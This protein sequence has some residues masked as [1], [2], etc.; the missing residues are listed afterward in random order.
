MSVG[1]NAC[2]TSATH[3]TSPRLDNI[4][5]SNVD[6]P[7]NDVSPRL[8]AQ[9]IYDINLRLVYALRSIGKDRNAA[10]VLCAVL[11]TPTPPSKFSRYNNILAKSLERVAIV[12]MKDA[13][14]QAVEV[15]GG[16]RDL[17]VALDGTWQKRG[18]VSLNG[19]VTATS[20]DTG[21]VVDVEVMSKFCICPGK[22]NRN[23]LPNCKANFHGV[24][25]AMEVQGATNIFFSRS[26][27]LHNARYVTYL[28][29]GDSKGFQCV[30]DADFY[31]DTKVEKLECINHVAKR[32]GSM[33]RK[34]KAK[35]GKSKLSDVKTISGRNRL[36][37][38]AIIKVQ[39][40][41]DLAI[42]RNV[43]GTVE[44]MKDAIW[45]EFYHLSASNGDLLHGLCPEGETAGASTSAH[46]LQ[47]NNMT[48]VPTSTYQKLSCKR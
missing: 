26:I 24:S 3:L 45:A 29:D 42:R 18:H 31:E 1:C 35:M 20:V 39:K 34:L 41:Y 11:N 7:T 47:T 19:V 32:M 22:S 9:N 43:N 15:N 17:S 27:A 10:E 6:R 44:Q 14:E 13:V 40:Y 12:T 38:E 5:Q 25:G 16:S 48:T 46:F 21:L 33:L 30:V 23:H 28:G 36:T 4:K 2:K 8:P 37:N